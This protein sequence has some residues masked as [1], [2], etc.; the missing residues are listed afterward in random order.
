M[1]FFLSDIPFLQLTPTF[2]LSSLSI[3]LVLI[4]SEERDGIHYLFHT[5]PSL[6]M[7]NASLAQA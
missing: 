7:A 6:A 2:D 3:S 4:Y 1:L 5:N